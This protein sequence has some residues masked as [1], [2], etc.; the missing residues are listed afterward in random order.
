[1]QASFFTSLAEIFKSLPQHP[2]AFF[3]AI[4][5]LLSFV[6]LV[7]FGKDERAWLKL[8]AFVILFI[9]AGGVSWAALQ[10]SKPENITPISSEPDAP[11]PPDPV[12]SPFDFLPEHIEVLVFD[13][14]NRKESGARFARCLN[15]TNSGRKIDYQKNWMN[16]WQMRTTRIYYRRDANINYANMIAELLPGTQFVFNYERQ[17][18][19]VND[20]RLWQDAPPGSFRNMAGI[21]SSRDL[22]IFVG[23]DI[24]DW[25][26]SS[27]ED[28]CAISG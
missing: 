20:N 11:T 2:I 22:I 1:M 12:D 17:N 16:E 5:V 15:P 4:A 28:V 7:F 14:T 26:S 25:L 19:Y 23:T 9:G 3:G 8:T 13:A 24:S 21:N 27:T 10:Y 6:A 18:Q